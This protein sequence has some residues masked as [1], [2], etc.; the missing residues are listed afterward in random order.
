MQR[1]SKPELNVAPSDFVAASSFK[2]EK[3]E[4]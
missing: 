1:L 4:E 2:T 3:A